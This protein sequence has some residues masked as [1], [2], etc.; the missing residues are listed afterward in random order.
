MSAKQVGLPTTCGQ[1]A[2]A[3][4]FACHCG[5]VWTDVATLCVVAPGAPIGGC[6]LP[7]HAASKTKATQLNTSLLKFEIF[8]CSFFLAP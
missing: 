6:D 2:C 5:T 7:L 8:I 3:R 4:C 1:A